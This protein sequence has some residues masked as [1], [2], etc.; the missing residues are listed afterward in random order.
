MA[1]KTLLKHLFFIRKS[2]VSSCSKETNFTSAK[3]DLQNCDYIKL[4]MSLKR[5]KIK[6]CFSELFVFALSF[7]CFDAQRNPSVV[8]RI[9][10]CLILRKTRKLDC[11]KI[12]PDCKE[13][14]QIFPKNMS[15]IGNKTF[16]SVF[17]IATNQI[18]N[19]IRFP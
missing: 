10:H 1:S 5:R 16:T 17:P 15:K 19:K 13:T 11:E 3:K 14:Q 8:V 12:L 7:S 4:F 6:L 2:V 9:P 18:T